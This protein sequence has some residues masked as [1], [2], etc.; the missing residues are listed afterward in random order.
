VFEPGQGTQTAREPRP[1]GG[2]GDKPAIEQVD[3]NP[4]SILL[5]FGDMA[6]AERSTLALGREA[7]AAVDQAERPGVLRQAAHERV[8][9]SL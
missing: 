1:G 9:Q 6:I 3:C 8:I 7:V 2:V 5:V 4:A